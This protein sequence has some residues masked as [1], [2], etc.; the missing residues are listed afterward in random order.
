MRINL[1]MPYL[2]YYIINILSTISLISTN[3][4]TVIFDLIRTFNFRRIR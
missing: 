1:N 3:E 4:L 2:F